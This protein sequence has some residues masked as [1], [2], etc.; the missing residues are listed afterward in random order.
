MIY[1]LRSYWAAPGKAEALHNRF[2]SL[3]LRL[4]E[5]HNMQVV[6]FWTPDDIEK[7]GALIYMLAFPDREALAAAWSAFRADEEWRTGKAASEAN[8]A[9]VDRLESR[10]L[11]PTDYSPLQ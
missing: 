10:L 4:F 8:G 3:T 9:I 6:G 5:R 11:T 1:E 2:R 7:D